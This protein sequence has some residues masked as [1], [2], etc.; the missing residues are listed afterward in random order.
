MELRRK[1]KPV[2]TEIQPPA[3][4]EDWIAR[5]NADGEPLQ[6]ETIPDKPVRQPTTKAKRLQPE[7]QTK[8]EKQEQLEQILP[9][10][11]TPSAG[12][13]YISFA[14]DN[15]TLALFRELS[16]RFD[17]GNA[18]TLAHVIRN[19]AAMDDQEFAIFPESRLVCGNIKRTMSFL[20][21]QDAID[22]VSALANRL[23]IR[24][25]SALYRYLIHL[26]SRSIGISV[27]V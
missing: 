2:P 16:F 19:C 3:D 20:L 27:Q 14:I 6:A 26:M 18:G 13:R 23:R 17:L 15:V 5:A 7:L 22:K 21:P 8:Q 10:P 25:K 4:P 11:P 1:N 12:S 24:N 9:P